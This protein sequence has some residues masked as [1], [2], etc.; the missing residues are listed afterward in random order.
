[1]RGWERGLSP[2]VRRQSDAKQVA[3]A[4]VDGAWFLVFSLLSVVVSL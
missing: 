4:K 3:P 1:M 2:V